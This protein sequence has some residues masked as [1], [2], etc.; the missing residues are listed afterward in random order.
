MSGPAPASFRLV[1]VEW[2]DS[3]QSHGWE[4]ME[5]LRDEVLVCRSVGWL[6]C[7]GQH[8]KVVAPHTTHPDSDIDLRAAGTMTIPARSVLRLVEL[9]EVE[10]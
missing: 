7:D 2:E 3:H 4:S 1:L 10:A 8:A 6:V 9:G 5:G